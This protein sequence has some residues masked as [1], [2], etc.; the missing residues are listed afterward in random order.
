M[1]SSISKALA[2][3]PYRLLLKDA[4]QEDLDSLVKEIKTKHSGADVESSVCPTEASWE[5]DIIILLVGHTAFKDAPRDVLLSRI[6]VDTV[7]LWQR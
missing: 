2:K 4:R 1:G 3:G 5:A 7:G 6:V